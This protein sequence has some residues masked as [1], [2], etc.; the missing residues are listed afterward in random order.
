[1]DDSLDKS[2]VVVV[3][4]GR[5]AP[6]DHGEQAGVC[7]RKRLEKDGGTGPAEGVGQVAQDTSEQG[8]ELQLS[9]DG[10]AAVL[11]GL[12]LEELFDQEVA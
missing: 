6:A 11:L 7:D 4:V 9:L 1:M 2:L 3:D 12:E 5:R 10:V 8:F